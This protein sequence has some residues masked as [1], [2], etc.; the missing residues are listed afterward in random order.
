M[1][2]LGASLNGLVP[3][4]LKLLEGVSTLRTLIFI[5]RH[6]ISSE[7]NEKLPLS[8]L[9]VKKPHYRTVTLLFKPARMMTILTQE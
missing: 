3:H 5:C 1:P 8:V 4:A 2:A 9:N 6:T 7:L